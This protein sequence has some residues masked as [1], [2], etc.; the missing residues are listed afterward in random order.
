VS[1]RVV[2]VVVRRSARARRARIVVDWERN[3]EVVLPRR[4][5]AA[6]V[7]RLLDEHGAWLERQLS[8]G[9]PESRLG[10]QRDDVVWLGGMAL[11][12]PDVADLG[13]W[14]RDQARVDLERAAAHEAKRLGLAYGRLAIRDQRT[15][16][17]SCSTRGTLSFNWRLV[18][19][20]SAVL[21][22]VVV[23]ELCHLRRHDHSR[24]FWRLVHQARPTYAGERAWLAAHG[25]EL[26]AYRVPGWP[27]AGRHSTATGR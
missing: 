7:E 18:L 5:P 16:W 8:K 23:H 9:E 4:A 2:E 3:V 26:L 11:P 14:Y 19:A 13:A 12:R 1:G 24:A 20:P 6:T 22:Y 21:S 27:T 10:L 25:R 15:R 17:G